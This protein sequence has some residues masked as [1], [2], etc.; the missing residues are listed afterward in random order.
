MIAAGH[1]GRCGR[2]PRIACL[3]QQAAARPVGRYIE[4]WKVGVRAV[5]AEARDVSVDQ[6]GVPLHDVLVS[7]LEP[8]ARWMWRVDDEDVGPLDQPFEY[9]CGVRR[10]QV[11]R[12]R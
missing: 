4:A 2:R 5:V 9:F 10:F 11:E 8:L 7:E 6:P 3:R 1:H 12:Q